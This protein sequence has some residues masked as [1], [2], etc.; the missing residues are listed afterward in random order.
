MKNEPLKYTTLKIGGMTCAM[1]VKTVENVLSRLDGVDEATVNLA[2]EKATIVYRG[3]RIDLTQIKKAIE[4]S[5]YYYLG[6]E[7]GETEKS[8][9]EILAKDFWLKKIRIWI[10]LITGTFL[11]VPM[12]VEMHLPI[13][14]HYLQLLIS[15]PVFFFLSLPIFR[16]AFVS[17]KNHSLNMDVMYAMGIGVAFAASV[18]GTFEIVLTHE[19]MFYETAIFLATFLIIGRYLESK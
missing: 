18:F 14:I 4:S 17:L 2:T 7:G 1:C 12:F 3:G 10:G 15:T 19:F 11:M 13:S 6:A 9:E 16:A 8:A 5:G